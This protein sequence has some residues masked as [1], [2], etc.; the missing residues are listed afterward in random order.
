MPLDATT[1]SYEPLARLVETSEGP[2]LRWDAPHR[3]SL[4]P[5]QAVTTFALF[6][7][8][9]ALGGASGWLLGHTGL[10][11]AFASEAVLAVL[12]FLRYA[13][14]ACDR[15]FITLSGSQLAVECHSGTRMRKDA[16]DADWVRVECDENTGGL[17]RLSQREATV[18]VGRHLTPPGRWLMAQELRRALGHCR[19]Q[20][21]W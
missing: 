8:T 20:V 10:A 19:T 9:G 17:V 14:H 1:A 18:S 7:V 4:T 3:P 15:E 5:R 6:A 16:F 11:I 12:L 21:R 2:V 13:R